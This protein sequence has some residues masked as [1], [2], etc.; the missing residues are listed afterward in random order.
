M[1]APVWDD[2]LLTV[3][4]PYLSSLRHIPALLTADIWTTSGLGEPSR[5]YRPL[6]MLSY[7]VNARLS[8]A[9]ALSFHAGNVVLHIA[10]GCLFLAYLRDRRFAR[11]LALRFVTALGFALAPVNVEAVAWIA[12]RFD[13]LGVT[14]I[15]GALLAN[16]GERPRSKVATAALLGLALLCKESFVLGAAILVA[17][18]LVVLRRRVRAEL[19][20][21]AAFAGAVVAFLVARKLV[22][23]VS[24]EA[25]TA[26]GFRTLVE[27]F[28]FLVV[29]Y[30]RAL[31]DAR[32]LD[33]F[34]PYAPFDARTTAAA[35]AVVGV[36]T[37]LVAAWLWRSR[38]DDDPRRGGIALGL[39]WVL[40]GFAPV[41]LAGPN[42]GMVGDRYAYFPLLGVFIVA[43]CVASLGLEPMRAWLSAYGVPLSPTHLLVLVIS[44]LFLGAEIGRTRKRILDWR[45]E[46]TLFTASL[47]DDPENAYALYS[48]GTLE[49]E[50][51]HFKDADSLLVRALAK[52]PS[53]WRSLDSLCYVRLHERQLVS[54]EALC[55]E[56]IAQNPANPRGWVNLAS[57]Y[58]TRGDW[59]AGYDA[60]SHALELKPS[61]A[62]P[63]Y[64]RAACFA[65]L[66]DYDDARADLAAA[67][68]ADPAHAGARDLLRR[69]DEREPR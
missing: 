44:V 57:V 15:L 12:G 23:V 25:V 42:L 11:S 31:I 5:F 38:R 40:L 33:P 61:A 20:K 1:N 13:L 26:T 21:Y 41:A 18:D 9:S 63:H 51:G 68:L 8:G 43:C 55:R 22:G 52:S 39:V 67:L 35:I 36:V 66:G 64:L 69:I 14:C 10:N 65:N 4:N 3:R 47:R 50:D 34:R 58:V 24:M 62:E 56:S 32:I 7:L 28:A 45:D 19:F 37:L 30:G 27:S 6:P 2:A 53:S 59:P 60:S 16:G 17:D 48:L 46:R 54:A 49:A 29:T